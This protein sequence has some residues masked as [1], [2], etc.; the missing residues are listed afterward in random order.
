V[1]EE[2]YDRITRVRGREEDGDVVWDAYDYDDNFLLT[3]PHSGLEHIIEHPDRA[4]LVD[5]VEEDGSLTRLTPGLLY[6]RFGGG[7]PV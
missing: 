2:P 4:T 6:L 3:M 7:P 1:T 5:I